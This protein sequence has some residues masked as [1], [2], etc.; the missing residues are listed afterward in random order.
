MRFQEK[1]LFVW[2]DFFF[3]FILLL[4]IACCIFFIW[5]LCV[6]VFFSSFR[7]CVL[8]ISLRHTFANLYSLYSTTMAVDGHWLYISPINTDQF[9][10]RNI[11]HKSDKLFML[12]YLYHILQKHI[13]NMYKKKIKQTNKNYGI[14]S[15][16]IRKVY[17]YMCHWYGYKRKNFA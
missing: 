13:H 1:V 3:H 14:K 17:V 11:K 8:L 2:F 15:K 10:Q 4:L 9:Y 7:R 6:R 16:T 5:C 12:I